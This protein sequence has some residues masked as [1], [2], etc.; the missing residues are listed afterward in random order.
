MKTTMYAVLIN[1]H[2]G[3][4]VKRVELCNVIL[5]EGRISAQRYN[6][7]KDQMVK[8]KYLNGTPKAHY[9]SLRTAE[10]LRDTFGGY[11]AY[12]YVRFE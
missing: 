11:P 1:G 12:T 3:E 4:E 8:V 10:G 6:R 7:L 5:D 2:T 9:W